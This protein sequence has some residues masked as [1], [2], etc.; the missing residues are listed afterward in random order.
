MY[1]NLTTPCCK[2]GLAVLNHLNND[3]ILEEKVLNNQSQNLLT[4]RSERIT[5]NR[6][7]EHKTPDSTHRII[8]LLESNTRATYS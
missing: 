3:C 2:V 8:A 1:V 7:H 5:C 6:K 4:C